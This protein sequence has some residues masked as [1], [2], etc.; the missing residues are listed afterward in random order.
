[1]IRLS[2]AV[3]LVA[4]LVAGTISTAQHTRRT[5][6]VDAVTVRASQE[7]APPGGMAQMKIRV[8]NEVLIVTGSAKFSFPGMAAI[9]GI[10]V[11]SPTDD[12]AAGVAVVHGTDVALSIVSPNATLGTDSDY[13][14]VTVLARVPVD[15]PIGATFP[16]VLDGTSLQLIGP[17]GVAY[18][19]EVDSGQLVAWPSLSIHEV[20]PGSATLSSGSRVTILGSNFQQRTEMRFD[21]TALAQVLFVSP[22][23]IDVVLAESTRMHGLEVKAKNPDGSESEYFSYQRT[24]RTG[25]ASQSV[26]RDI[27]PIF[28]SRSAQSSTLQLS[29]GTRGVALQNLNRTEVVV[30]AEL[31]NASGARAASTTVKLPSNTFLVRELYELFRVRSDGDAIVRLTSATPVQALGVSIDSAGAAHPRLPQ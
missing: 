1:M 21:E 31:F 24:S 29:G 8:T 17:N 4:L 27:V 14:L 22:T 25:K 16:F 28:Q 13:P 7:V 15:A 11:V 6:A 5:E 12:G 20:K 26:M 3:T 10:S 30:A 23:R 9:E 2:A 18:A 19:T